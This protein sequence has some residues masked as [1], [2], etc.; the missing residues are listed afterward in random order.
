MLCAMNSAMGDVENAFEQGYACAPGKGPHV[1]PGDKRLKYSIIWSNEPEMRSILYCPESTTRTLAQWDDDG[2]NYPHYFDGPD[3]NAFIEVPEGRHQLSLYFYDPTPLIEQ[4]CCN[5]RRDY[6]IEIRK[7]SPDIH[8]DVVMRRLSPEE[9]ALPSD[10]LVKEMEKMIGLPVLARS[11]VK[12]FASQGVYK[13]FILNGKG[14]YCV[15]IIRNYSASATLNGIF[16]SSLDETKAALERYH[17]SR[18][19]CFWYGVETPSPPALDTKELKLLPGD[20]L[21]D[22]GDSQNMEEQRLSGIFGSRSRGIYAYRRL[23]SLP[24]LENLKANWRWRLKIWD[25]GD[26]DLFVKQMDKAWRSLQDLYPIYR[27]SEWSAYASEKTIPFS[28]E[29]VKKMRK[30]NIDWKQYLPNSPLKPERT[31]EEMKKWLKEN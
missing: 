31:V 22:W 15:K 19:T 6:I 23:L 30:K 13:N 10:Y 16:L 5:R 29:E 17:N 14:C 26:K 24:G 11:R 27:S 7:L 4:A 21:A 25:S 2:G 1:K 9:A 3:L 28:V 18:H 8:R 20:L 12:N